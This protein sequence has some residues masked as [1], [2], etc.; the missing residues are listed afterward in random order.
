MTSQQNDIIFAT[1]NQH[2]LREVVDILNLPMFNLLSLKDVGFMD[3]I[4]ETADTLSGNAM[5]KAENH[6][7]KVWKRMYSL[8]TQDWRCYH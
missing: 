6:L 1:G 5:I 4:P 3:D 8:K 2:K 7:P